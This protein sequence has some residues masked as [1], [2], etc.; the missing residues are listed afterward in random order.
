MGG[1]V[2]GQ[3]QD[4]TF[5]ALGAARIILKH[6]TPKGESATSMQKVIESEGKTKEGCGRKDKEKTGINITASDD[7]DRHYI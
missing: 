1:E 2:L 3:C 4:W 6:I 7:I 5:P